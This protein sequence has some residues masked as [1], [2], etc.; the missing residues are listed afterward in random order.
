MIDILSCITLEH[1]LTLVLMA[2]LLCIS[3]A[4]TYHL[5]I[6]R[7]FNAEG[8]S[9]WAWIGIASIALGTTVWCTH[10]IAMLSYQAEVPVVIDPVLTMASLVFPVFGF[11]IAINISMLRLGHL[12]KILGGCLI[13]LCVAALHYTGMVAYRIDGLISWDIGYIA[14]SVVFAC[15]FTVAA[16]YTFSRGEVFGVSLPSIGLFSLGV[17][18]LHFTGMTAL[19][20]VPLSLNQSP[21]DSATFIGLSLATALAGGMVILTGVICFFLDMEGRQQ[22]YQRLLEMAMTDPLTQLPNRNKFTDDLALSFTNAEQN[23][24]FLAVIG[25]DLNRFKE[26]NDTYGHEAGDKVLIE[27]SKSLVRDIQPSETIARLGG[28]EF[29]ACKVFS[30]HTELDDF[31]KR[32]ETAV[33]TRIPHD[34][35]Y[36]TVGGSIGYAVFP[37]DGLTPDTLRSNADLAMYRAKLHPTEQSIRFEASMDEEVRQRREISSALSRAITEDGLELHYQ[38]QA[39]TQTGKISGMEALLRWNMPGRGPI[40]P[41]VFIP[42]AEQSGLIVRLGEWVLRKACSDAASWENERKVA[43][44]VSPLQ[45]TQIDLPQIIHQTLIETGLPP[46][47]LEIELTETAIIEDRDR[48]LHV[49]RQIKALGVKVALDDFGTGYS[50]LEI[51][52]SFPFDKIKLDRFFM[53]EIETSVESKALV[54]S[55][56][57]IGQSLSIPVLAEGVETEAQLTILRT[58][59]CDEVQGFLLGRPLPVTDLC[60]A[61]TLQLCALEQQEKDRQT[62]QKFKLIKSA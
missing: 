19:D 3:G 27:V 61:D 14:L 49:L 48:S 59:G 6:R 54:R 1:N 13:G 42:V 2:G 47:R 36:L 55:V 4:F 9:R 44:N 17:V 62:G 53:S 57:S 37:E 43:V 5:L 24:Q 41:A 20:V 21:M 26:V 22:G 58:E 46:H 60:N 33:N 15:A 38:L 45:L 40:S 31:I 7:A 50:S 28:D 11:F 10:F 25:I 12:T 16:N 56:L 51:L 32:L 18:S 34:D 52:R 23:G 29:A 35:S 39:S 8:P 30:H